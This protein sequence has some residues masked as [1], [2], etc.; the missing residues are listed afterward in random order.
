MIYVIKYYLFVI[1]HAQFKICMNN[2]I[3]ILSII[4]WLIYT[5]EV[6]IFEWPKTQFWTYWENEGLSY[7]GVTFNWDEQGLSIMLVYH[8][9]LRKVLRE[10][11]IYI[12]TMNKLCLKECRSLSKTVS[13]VYTNHRGNLTHPYILL[14]E[15]FLCHKP[16]Y[17]AFTYLI[18]LWFPFSYNLLLR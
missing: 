12:I 1:L 11:N 7:F 14:C 13:L 4:I 8:L 5:L 9:T 3:S 18:Y 17:N 15:Y 6:Y 2:K 10:S 16:H